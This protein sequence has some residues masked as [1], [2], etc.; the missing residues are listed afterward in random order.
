MIV[1]KNTNE[2]VRSQT[3]I[4]QKTDLTDFPSIVTAEFYL[5]NVSAATSVTIVNQVP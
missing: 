2:I 1:A 3:T 4:L 5:T